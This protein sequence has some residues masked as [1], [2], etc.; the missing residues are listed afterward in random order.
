M[1]TRRRQKVP[2]KG[3]NAE[4]EWNAVPESK[5]MSIMERLTEFKYSAARG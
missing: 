2:G 4:R 3:S 1:E 5:R